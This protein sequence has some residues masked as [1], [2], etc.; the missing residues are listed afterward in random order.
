MAETRPWPVQYGRP[1]P[2]CPTCKRPKW[3]GGHALNED[4]C[5]EQ[6]G[7]VCRLRARA[8]ALEAERDEARRDF[9]EV[10]TERQAMTALARRRGEAL[11][12]AQAYLRE[13]EWDGWRSRDV[14]NDFIGEAFCLGCNAF[15][16]DGH[17]PSCALAAALSD[18]RESEG[19]GDR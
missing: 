13:T 8:A 4:E 16:S 11:R 18:E 10:V 14:A 2:A 12:R 9:D 19:G 5:D 7:E 15:K 17:L 1:V 6:D 3:D